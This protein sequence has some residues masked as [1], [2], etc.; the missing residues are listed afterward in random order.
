MASITAATKHMSPARR[1]AVAQIVER[2]QQL[3]KRSSVGMPGGGGGGEGLPAERNVF[4]KKS[5]VG[6]GGGSLNAGKSTPACRELS[7]H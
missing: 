6:Q 1:L 3:A 4:P 5:G 7:L 2:L